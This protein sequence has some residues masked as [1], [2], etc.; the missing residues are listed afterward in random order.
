MLSHFSQKEDMIKKIINK[1]LN[2]K[3]FLY[4]HGIFKILPE[5]DDWFTDV[6]KDSC[7]PSE[8]EMEQYW[9]QKTP[10][11]DLMEKLSI[12]NPEPVIFDFQEIR[13]SFGFWQRD[14]DGKIV[15]PIRIKDITY[16]GRKVES[17][18]W[19]SAEAYVRQFDTIDLNERFP[20][21]D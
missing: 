15:D 19:F 5:Y 10:P 12:F 14:E 18:G 2:F 3:I 13:L 7:V 17:D 1:D 8:E 16:L 9:K 21:L 11:D 20:L 4:T 6:V